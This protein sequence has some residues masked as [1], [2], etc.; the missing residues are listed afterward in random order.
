MKFLVGIISGII[1]TVAVAAGV[2]V[3]SST[4]S[5]ASAVSLSPQTSSMQQ[6]SLTQM[7][8]AHAT[9]AT[10]LQGFTGEL[11][12]KDT[13]AFELKVTLRQNGL[14]VDRDVRLLIARAKVTNR[15]GHPAQ[16]LDDATARVTGRMLPRSA[17]RYD[18]DG[19][20]I[21]TFAV[22]R[23]IVLAFTPPDQGDGEEAQD[24]SGD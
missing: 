13:G 6:S 4:T 14:L 21:P 15:L 10:R 12:R 3:A 23:V 24:S 8:V 11:S 1:V 7:T 19:R 2:A 16:L 18:D 20:L 22:N 9:V 17:W 5:S